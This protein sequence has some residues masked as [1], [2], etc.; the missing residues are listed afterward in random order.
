MTPQAL[1]QHRMKADGRC[2][3]CC[4]PNDRDGTRCTF[5]LARN[6]AQVRS[7]RAL[8]MALGRCIDCPQ[9]SDG[10]TRCRRCR[11]A[12][13]KNDKRRKAVPCAA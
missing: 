9:P 5:C 2:G 3:R 11:V 10:Y 7:R 12:H 13:T 6:R 8:L 4:Q 1:H